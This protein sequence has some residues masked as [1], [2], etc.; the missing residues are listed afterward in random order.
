MKP[1]IALKDLE[2]DVV[3]LMNNDKRSSPRSG[4]QAR[5]NGKQ[6]VDWILEPFKKDLMQ[7]LPKVDAFFEQMNQQEHYSALCNLY[8]GMTRAKKALY[9]INDRSG[10][11]DNSMLDH[12]KNCLMDEEG[13]E[14]ELFNGE[15]FDV[16]WSTGDVNWHSL[17][18]NSNKNIAQ[19]KKEKRN[20]LFPS[21]T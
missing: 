21:N 9:M 14:K 3:I 1:F 19:V 20:H 6:E 10:V 12:L 7:A 15:K 8:V 16:L 17:I 2:Y 18:P 5:R 4:I 11:S 13:T